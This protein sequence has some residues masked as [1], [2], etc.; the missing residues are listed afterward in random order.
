[1]NAND[2]A[3]YHLAELDGTRMAAPVPGKRI[4]SFKK[5]YEDEPGPDCVGEGDDPERTDE[6]RGVNGVVKIFI[7]RRKTE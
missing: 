2:N 7:H 4:K 1:M 3:T 6:D 5:Q